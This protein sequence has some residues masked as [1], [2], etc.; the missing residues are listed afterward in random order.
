MASPASPDRFWRPS[1]VRTVGYLLAGTGAAAL[2]LLL[3]HLLLGRRLAQQLLIQTGSEVASNLVLGEVALERFSPEVLGQIS[4]MQLVVGRRPEPAAA[5]RWVGRGDRRLRWQAERLQAELCRRLGRCPAVQPASSPRRGVWVEM[6]SPLEPVWLFVSLPSPRGWPP[7]PLLL[8]LSI[9]LGALG[10]LLL[11][12]TLEIQRPLTRLQE[13]LA[14][15]GLEALP[16][17]LPDQGAPAVRQLMA[18]FNAMLLRLEDSGRERTTML[19][20]IAHDLRSPLTRLRLRLAL[21]AEGPMAPQELERAQADI[22]SIERITRQFMIFAGA[23]AGES[24]VLVPLDALVAE[25][26]AAVGEVPLELDL[27]P[28][29]RRVRPIALA[30]AVGNLLDNALTY[31]RPPLRLVLRPL[32]PGDGAMRVH[33]EAGSVESGFEIQVWDCGEGIDR[34]QWL[35]AMTPFQRLDQ[36]RGGEGHCGLGLAIA[37]KVARDHG[38]DLRRL[39]ATAAADSSP[40]RF[41]VALRAWPLPGV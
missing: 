39:E 11:F 7:D 40:G 24:P 6:A 3:L 17:A 1:L 21:A 23:E 34:E 16:E 32:G 9:G 29:V 31:G 5:A 41:A 38:G 14:D 13:A 22:R 12:L 20:G 4:G 19:A 18:R 30:R 36:A 25:S 8:S 28:L 27:E 35:K 2:S 10:A 26:A 33:G 37:A 15:V